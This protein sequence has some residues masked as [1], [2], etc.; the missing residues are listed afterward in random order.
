MAWLVLSPGLEFSLAASAIL[1]AT[2]AVA[3]ALAFDKPRATVTEPSVSLGPPVIGRAP[4][5][6]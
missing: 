6:P 3:F 5:E 4:E 2:G 1:I